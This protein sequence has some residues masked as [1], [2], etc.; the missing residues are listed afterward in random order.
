M[1]GKERR[2]VRPH[3]EE[4]RMAERHDAGVAQD[5]VQRDGEHRQQRDLVGQQSVLGQGE[6]R[7]RE[8][9]E[10]RELPAAP[11]R[12]PGQRLL[13]IRQASV[14]AWGVH[15]APFRTKRPCGRHSRITIMS[16]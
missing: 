16:V 3:A 1:L 6:P 5:Q 10:E 2:T 11:A 13:H 8:R 15:R 7:Q 9:R 14:V 4:G 12:M